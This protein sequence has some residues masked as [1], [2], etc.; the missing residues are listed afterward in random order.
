MSYIKSIFQFD[1]EN[2]KGANAP[3]E[4]SN[5]YNFDQNKN[6]NTRYWVKSISKISPS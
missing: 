2:L 3:G 1:L 4:N 5:A 6:K